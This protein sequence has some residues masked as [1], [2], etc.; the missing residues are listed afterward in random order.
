MTLN[1]AGAQGRAGADGRQASTG[2]LADRMAAALVHHEPGWRL[3]RLTA[4][5]RRYSVSTAEVDAAI[6][7]LAIRHLV[8]RLPD[9]QVYRASPAEYW[10]PLEGLMGLTSR[11]DPMGGQ[12]ACKSRTCALRRP[13]EDIGRALALAPAERTLAVRCQWTVGGEPA[14]LSASYL[15]Q[16]FAATV[17]DVPSREPPGAATG[18]A[19][20]GARAAPPSVALTNGEQSQAGAV[21]PVPPGSLFFPWRLAP[22]ILAWPRALQAEL[23][24]PPPSAAR[25]LRLGPGETAVTVTVSFATG[26]AGSPLALTTAMLR[27]ELFRVVFQLSPH[28]AAPGG[29]PGIDLA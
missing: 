29:L 3:P 28:S 19:A 14:A 16:R 27:L 2:V 4:L 22:G 26:E 25:T 18:H 24:L 17:A 1:R 11:V 15:P 20:G 12:L 6:D 8:R 7:E 21:A 9:G 5:A 13:P 23:G 10:V